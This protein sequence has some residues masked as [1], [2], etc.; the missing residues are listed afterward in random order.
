[1][2]T[3]GGK[4]NSASLLHKL[5]QTLS[6]NWQL[7]ALLLPALIWLAVFMYAPMYGVTIAFKDYNSKL[8]ILGSPFAGLKYFRQFFSTNIFY[9]TLRNTL[10][11]SG[12]QLAFGFPVPILFALLLNQLRF[13]RFRKVVQTISYAP[14]F[15]SN[16]VVVSILAVVMSPSGF[17]NGFIQSTGKAAV[18]FMTRPEYFRPLYVGSGIWQSMGFNAIIYLA[19]LAG[20]P[21]DLHEAAI[22]DGASKIKRIIHIDLPTIAPTIIIM[23]ILAIGNLMSVGYEKAFLMQSGMNTSVSEIVSTYVYKAGLVNAQYSFATAVGLF[24]SVINLILLSAANIV[25]RKTADFGLF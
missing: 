6:Y 1:M 21:P 3:T 2:L 19:A 9:I 7:W 8:G 23:L 14:Y 12:Q 22:V 17:V 20:V 24:N 25:S 10:I 5:T 13:A 18:L 4:K 15:I 11:V 16:V